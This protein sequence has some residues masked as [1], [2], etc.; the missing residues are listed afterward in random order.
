M[1]VGVKAA[2][3]VQE[4]SFGQMAAL[5][6]TEVKGVDIVKATATLKVVP[7]ALLDLMKVSFK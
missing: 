5:V 6:G 1:R 2:E 4:K 7:P 3:L